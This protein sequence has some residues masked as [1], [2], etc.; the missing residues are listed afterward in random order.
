MNSEERDGIHKMSYELGQNAK[1]LENLK[2]AFK[3]HEQQDDRRHTENVSL[4]K[5]INDE[6]KELREALA[7]VASF[8][9]RRLALIASLGMMLL[10]GVSWALGEVAKWAIGW[11]AIKIKLGG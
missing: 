5:S 10:A 6:I 11:V 8:H 7:P 3:D 9:K 1:E 4:L 2:D